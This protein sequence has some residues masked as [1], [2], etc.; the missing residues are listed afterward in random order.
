[1]PAFPAGRS[2]KNSPTL[3]AVDNATITAS[4]IIVNY[5]GRDHLEKC[6]KSLQSENCPSHEI[7]LL[8][9]ASTDGSATFVQQFFP[10]VRVIQNSINSGFGH[11]NNV[12]AKYARGEYL[13]FLNPDTEVEPGWL[14]A[15]IA[16][17]NAD[18]KAGLAT[19]K[20]VLLAD[21]DRINTCGN[22]IHLTGLT[23]CRGLGLQR[24]ALDR[25]AEVGAVSGAAFAIRRSLFEDLGGFDGDFFLYMEDTDLSL[26]ARLA[27]Y[28]C[29][30]APS[31]VVCHDY[32]LRIG[33]EKTFYQE[34][35]RYLILL[36]SLRARTLVVL[37]PAFLLA[38]VLTWAFVI[39]QDRRRLENKLR[40]Y[41]WI[42]VHWR[43]IIEKRRKVQ[44]L[45][46]VADRCLLTKFTYRLAFEQTGSGFVATLAHAAFDPLFFALHRLALAMVRW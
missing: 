9:N 38:E 44:S 13:A 30:C 2:P 3:A 28:T 27:G 10:E 17:L 34:R 24:R 15:L 41:R 18:P 5:N 45:R 46:R 42:V 39:L 35:N 19:S 40:A 12:A 11:G 21:R 33:P 7:V 4:V 31:S 8:D 25:I 23:L 29:V 6:L 20:I 1:M 37:T 14:D 26:R 32:T 22:E 43:Q 16:A 36:K